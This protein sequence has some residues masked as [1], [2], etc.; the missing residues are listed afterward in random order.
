MTFCIFDMK[1]KVVWVRSRILLLADS[2]LLENDTGA[3]ARRHNF[4][5]SFP[6][7]G[8]PRLKHILPKTVFNC[9]H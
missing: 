1:A 4:A 8:S 9:S 2:L 7:A 5:R 6:A 3:A